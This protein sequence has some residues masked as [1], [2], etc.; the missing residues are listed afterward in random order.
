MDQIQK[1]KYVSTGGKIAITIIIITGIMAAE[2]VVLPILLALFLSIIVTKPILYLRKKKIPN[3]VAI[4]IVFIGIVLIFMGLGALLG[5][6]LANLSEDIPNY[7]EQF[8]NI[9]ASF[10]GWID[11]LGYNVTAQDITNRIDAG[12]V[13]KLLTNSLSE[14]G[15]VMQDSILIMFIAVLMLLEL[16]DFYIKSHVVEKKYGKNSLKSLDRIA[17]SVRQY[18]WIQ[19]LL[20]L[21]TG[22]LVSVSLVII[23]VD[24]PILWGI[25]AFLLNYIPNIGSIIAAIPTI[26]FALIQLGPGAAFWTT[27]IYL[28]INMVVGNMIQPKVMGKG[29]GLSTLVVF[30]SLLVWGFI[31][32]TIG[33]FL[34]VPLTM[35]IKIIL[36]QNP[37]TKWMAVMMG[38]E[39]EAKIALNNS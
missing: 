32:G 10:L 3:T 13:L 16:D 7:E 15:G 31:F 26:L 21:L 27:L 11:H 39:D 30:L 36:E 35:S 6:S 1:T 14:L 28:V 19:T 17:K 38:T 18:L 24:Y 9:V 20:S 5:K 34:S 25:V 37:D 12:K 4:I 33:M 22:V 8:S 23:G 29:L 2:S